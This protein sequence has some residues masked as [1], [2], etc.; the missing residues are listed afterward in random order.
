MIMDTLEL[1]ELDSDELDNINGGAVN[2]FWGAVAAGLIIATGGE[3]LG[4]WDNFKR[5]LRGQPEK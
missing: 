4:D 5:G 1:R 2:C 3:I